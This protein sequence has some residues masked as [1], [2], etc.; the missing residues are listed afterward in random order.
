MENKF[1]LYDGVIVSQT[2]KALSSS[3]VL[4]YRTKSRPLFLEGAFDCFSQ[5]PASSSS[6]SSHVGQC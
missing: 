2:I 4:E 1:G 6:F 5:V 3:L